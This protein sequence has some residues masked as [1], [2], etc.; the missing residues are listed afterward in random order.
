MT[1]KLKPCPFCG[2]EAEILPYLTNSDKN[3]YFVECCNC[4]ARV[5]WYNDRTRKRVGKDRLPNLWNNRKEN[6]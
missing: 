1:E 5:D 2:G 4:R 6:N 3:A